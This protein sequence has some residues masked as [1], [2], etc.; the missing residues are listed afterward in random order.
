MTGKQE[1]IHTL[2][3]SIS[4]PGMTL[5]PCRGHSAMPEDILVVIPPGGDGTDI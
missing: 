2:Q 5:Q 4:Q 1:H 3:F